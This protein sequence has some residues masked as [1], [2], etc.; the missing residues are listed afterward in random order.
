MAAPLSLILNTAVEAPEDS[1]LDTTA[2]QPSNIESFRFLDLPPEL[3][4]RVYEHLTHDVMIQVPDLGLPVCATVTGAVEKFFYPSI[5]LACHQLRCEYTA[6]IMRPMT[7]RVLVACHGVHGTRGRLGD[8]GAYCSNIPLRVL[9]QITQLRFDI[10]M[11]PRGPHCG[12]RFSTYRI[13]VSLLTLTYGR[14]GVPCCVE[15]CK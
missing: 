13:T 1:L 8:A 5:M 3:R 7:L 9:A 11:G 2:M 10:R 12:M 15:S 14:R 6:I 4:L